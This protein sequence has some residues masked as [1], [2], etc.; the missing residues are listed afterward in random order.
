MMKRSIYFF[1]AMLVAI[2]A[3]CNLSGSGSVQSLD[4]LAFKALIN[5]SDIQ[6][7]DVR[8]PK[9]FAK[10]SLENAINIDINV[11]GFSER[12]VQ[13]LSKDRPVAVFCHSGERS[14]IAADILSDMGFEVFNLTEGLIG[15]EE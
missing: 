6:L 4:S 5:N 13:T 7:V 12:A 10:G 2:V 15:W 14:R 3:S 8:T 1:M 9:E 11:D